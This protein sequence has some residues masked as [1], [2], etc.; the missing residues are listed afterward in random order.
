MMCLRAWQKGLGVGNAEICAHL[1]SNGWG[2]EVANLLNGNFNPIIATGL[3][4][5][6]GGIAMQSHAEVE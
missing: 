6:H 4:L 2:A 1:K 5:F 3:S